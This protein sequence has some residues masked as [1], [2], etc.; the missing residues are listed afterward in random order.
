MTVFKYGNFETEIDTA[1]LDFMEKFEEK[2]LALEKD[3][4]KVNKQG[5]R[6]EFI[7]AMCNLAFAYFDSLFGEGTADLMFDGKFNLR[8]CDGA[9]FAL[10]D[11]IETDQKEYNDE[12]KAG[13]SKRTGN[14]Q[15]RRAKK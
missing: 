11:A 6:S 3:T 10:A 15:Q 8:M 5:K 14:R 13:L 1:D 7:R 4:D 2:S 12:V 9:M